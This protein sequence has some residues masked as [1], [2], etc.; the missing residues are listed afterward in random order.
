MADYCKERGMVVNPD[1]AKIMVVNGDETDKIP[2]TV[3]GCTVLNCLAYTHWGSIFTAEA[4]FSS[5]FS[6]HVS[7]K[8]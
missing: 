3:Q 8:P 4:K 7:D 6:Q 2:I 1:K 5:I